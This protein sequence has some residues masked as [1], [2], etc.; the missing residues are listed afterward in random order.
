MFT[1]PYLSRIVP[2]TWS[3]NI[4]LVRTGMLVFFARLFVSCTETAGDVQLGGLGF[5]HYNMKLEEQVAQAQAVKKH[6]P[7]FV[8]TP[9]TLS[10]GNTIADFE[11]VKVRLL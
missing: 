3:W 4:E 8:I 1:Q 2:I 9:A 6:V 5:I 10:E 7:G 11:Q